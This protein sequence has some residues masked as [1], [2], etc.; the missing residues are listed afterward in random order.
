[1]NKKLAV[2]LVVILASLLT[3]CGGGSTG[4]GTVTQTPTPSPTL[5]PTPPP[6]PAELIGTY[7]KTLAQP[8]VLPPAVGVWML[9][10]RQ[11][12]TYEFD[13]LAPAG[14]LAGNYVVEGNHIT[15]MNDQCG[16]SPTYV[17]QLNGNQL[18]TTDFSGDQCGARH[19]VLIHKVWVKTPAT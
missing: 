8:D 2:L 14:G 13:S 5:T 16:G 18:T 3:A 12:G 10:L 6:I 19:D 17:W 15:F 1:M 11:D 4:G 7:V 9:K